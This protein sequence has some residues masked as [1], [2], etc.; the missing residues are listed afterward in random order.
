MKYSIPVVVVVI[1]VAISAMVYSRGGTRESLSERVAPDAEQAGPAAEAAPTAPPTSKANELLQT[2]AD[3]HFLLAGREGRKWA[4][5]STVLNGN[6]LPLNGVVSTML[7]DGTWTDSNGLRGKW[8]LSDDR[9]RII[10]DYERYKMTVHCKLL[11]L[12]ENKMVVEF[13]DVFAGTVMTM[14]PVAEPGDGSTPQATKE[15]LP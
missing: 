15:P 4:I 1:I 9:S 7:P 2:P 5:T 11:E 12:A 8:R 3:A 6:A 13:E 10:Y 14:E